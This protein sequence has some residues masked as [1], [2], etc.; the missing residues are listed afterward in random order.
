MA[1][2]LTF[3]LDG[4]D[5][6]SRVLDR[7]GDN[8]NRLGRR[9]L[10]AS[11]NGDAAMRRL[12]NATTTRMAGLQRDTDLGE[13][14]LK[15][16][17]G[18]LISLA[19]AAIP[20]AA[21]LAPVAAG[22]GAAA[23]A[24]AAFGAALGPQISAMSEAVDAEKAYTDAVA[25]SGRTSEAAVTAQ[26]EYVRTV[27]AL[28]PETRRAAAG[29]SVLKDEYKAWSDGLAKDTMAPVVKGMGILTALLPKTSGLV[30]GASTQLDRLMTVVAGGMASP[31]LDRL[32]QK[33]T[34]FATGTLQKVNDQLV[35]LMRTTDAGKVGG[36]VS[37]F[38]DYARAQGPVV[39]DTL[40]N[41]S[42]ALAN[43]LIAGSDV[44]VSMLDLIN[45]LSGIVSAVP[46]GAIATLL[47]LVVAIKLAKLAAVGMSAASTAMRAFGTSIIAMQAAAAAAPGRLS[48]VSAAIGSL[49]RGA[50]VALAGTGIGLLVIALGSLAS[51]G[52][53][54]PPDV[55]RLTTSLGKLAQTGKVSGEAAKAFGTDLGGLA[56]ALRTLSRP[57]NLDST[58]QFL[59]SLIGMDSTPVKEAK[60]NL[61]AVDK[62]LAGLVQGGKSELA[63]AAFDKL[64]AGM[65]AQGMS[66]GELRTKLDGYK[67]A[68]EDQAFEQQLAAQSMGLFGSQA[69]AVQAK[70]DAQ[71]ASADGLRQSIQALNDVNRQGLGGMVGFEA[72]IDAAA[73]AAKDNAGALDMS[74]GKLN[75][76]SEKARNAASALNDLAAKTDEAAASARQADAPWSTINGIYARGREKLI[77]SAQAMGL[78]RSQAKALA[79]QILQ[80][81]DKTARLKGNLEDLQAK[82]ADA[83]GRLAK[84]PSSKTTSIRGE[85]SDLQRKIAAAKTAI[86]GVQGKTVS[87]MVNYRS[88]KNPSSFAASIGGYA[89]GGKPKPGELAWVGEEGPE[90]MRF[91][92][93]G[94]EIYDH[95]SS[96]AMVA[97]ASAAGRDAGLG[98]RRGMTVSTGGVEASGRALAG[99]ILHGVRDE[100]QIASPSKKMKA[101]AADAGKGIIVGLTGSKAKI[102]SVSKD[103]VKDIW[104]AWKGTRSTK[105]SRLVK[106]VEKDTKKLQ[107][108]ASQRDSLA[109][110][111]ATAKKYASDLTA[112]ARRDASLGSLGIEDGKVTAGSIQ[113]GLQQKL[114]NMRQF[115]SYINT[116][117]KRGLSKT[118]LRQILDMGPDQGYAYAS[119]LAGA[120]SSTLKSINSTQSQISKTTT[121]LGQS[122]ADIL[123][124]SGKNA[125]KG[126]LKG[127]ESQQD[128]IEKQMV[129]IA[130]GMQKAIKKALGIKSPSTVMAQLG[131]Y[132]TEGLAAGLTDR[133]PVLDRALA[134]V[135]DRVASAQPVIGRPAI[136]AGSGGVTVHNHIEVNGA[137]DPVAVG[138]EL[139]KVLVKFGR[140]QGGTVTLKAG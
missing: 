44:G 128:A 84:A 93:G 69:Q 76:N 89:S 100:L 80:T 10:A 15:Q 94:T 117:A 66:A 40:R 99:A 16:L 57:S 33:F 8:A 85:I 25:K 7:A 79:A 106:M 121:K 87:V 60:E 123:Y 51:M 119:A 35:H 138:R 124:D 48:A 86:N 107:K 6:L 26:L 82:L 24:V 110:K 81:P 36:G 136:G 113:A 29:L 63:S 88:N 23:V 53:K 105:D 47:Q 30:K 134:T 64:A 120:S 39:A 54:A 122:G 130:K 11:I 129:K 18:T 37:E 96:M 132:S 43:I 70:L 137:M 131:R 140:V 61:D 55:D 91:G 56:D 115:M 101:L 31:G 83:K 34:A 46:P 108:L 126:F 22:A 38:M 74:G 111:I 102:S 4:R 78:T 72:A 27:S 52:K 65:K 49:S 45:G 75:L 92:G 112:N 118:L 125:G 97:D 1:T 109:S 20:A 133:M 21:S 62:A 17:K 116:L 5:H 67:S 104:A 73:K 135:T 19:P 77:A 95:R 32:N 9:L 103:L 42:Q 28:P 71:K 90:L 114:A 59:T 12:G 13:K 68:L 50:K 41:V 3:L 2:R 14:A 139:Q 127:L 58:Q 98:L